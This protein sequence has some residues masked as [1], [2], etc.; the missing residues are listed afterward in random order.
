MVNS[1]VNGWQCEALA[2]IRKTNVADIPLA[3]LMLSGM[4]LGIGGA[5]KHHSRP[6]AP[7][8]PPPEHGMG[9]WQRLWQ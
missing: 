5:F 6:Q 2:V 8:V 1:P 7:A 3:I 4:A 9:A